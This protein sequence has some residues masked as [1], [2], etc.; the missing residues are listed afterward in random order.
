MNILICYVDH[1]V[2]KEYGVTYHCEDIAKELASVCRTSLQCRVQDLL[3]PTKDEMVEAMKSLCSTAVIFSSM[4]SD[5]GRSDA[6][7]ES[8]NLSNSLLILLTSGSSLDQ[9]I[10]TDDGYA[11]M[12]ELSQISPNILL[13]IHMLGASVTYNKETMMSTKHSP[14]ASPT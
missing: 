9:Q 5:S 10:C 14:Y 6:G 4:S 1:P 2:G 13:D 7:D 12:E 8:T 11:T 3:Q